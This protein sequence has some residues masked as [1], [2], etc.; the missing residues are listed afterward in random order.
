MN[1]KRDKTLDIIAGVQDAKN[2][3]AVAD[4]IG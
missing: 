3:L 1:E 4:G 2:F